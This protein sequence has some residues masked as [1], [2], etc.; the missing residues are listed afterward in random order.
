MKDMF[1]TWYSSEVQKQMESGTSHDEI[2]VDLRLSVLKP[3]H[4][5]WL[6]SLFDL[7]T[8]SVG[9]RHIAKGWSKAGIAGVAEG[10]VALSP[11]DPFQNIEAIIV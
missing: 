1:T 10:K 9:K 5:T 6:V 11:E 3:L 2:E 7:V 8:S 4:A